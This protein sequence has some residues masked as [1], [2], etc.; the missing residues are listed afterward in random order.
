MQA[1]MKN[2][3]QYL[4]HFF[5]SR[6]TDSRFF[7]YYLAQKLNLENLEIEALVQEMQCDSA[8]FYRLA[9]CLAPREDQ[10]NFEDQMAEIADY[11]GLE[12]HGLQQLLK[13]VR[14]MDQLRA[15]SNADPTSPLMA[16][17]DKDESE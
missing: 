5:R 3:N 2:D 1:I 17:R 15:I 8:T 9:A 4:A 11:T 14:F 12:V 10:A 7:A 13:E 16:A 6:A